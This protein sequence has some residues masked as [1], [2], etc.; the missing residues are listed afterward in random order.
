MA[1]QVG[2]LE[3]LVIDQDEDGLLRGEESVQAVLEGGRLG[4]VVT[5]LR[6]AWKMRPYSPKISR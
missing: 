6:F 1:M 4:H 2:E 3:R 5:P